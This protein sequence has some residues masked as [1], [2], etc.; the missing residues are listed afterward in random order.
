MSLFYDLPS[1]VTLVTKG[2]G[3]EVFN[4]TRSLFKRLEEIP[5]LNDS[6]LTIQHGKEAVSE[7]GIAA[8]ETMIWLCGFAPFERASKRKGNPYS[9]FGTRWSWEFLSEYLGWQ[10]RPLP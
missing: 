10:W 5:T 4:E 3:I 9:R 8:L 1:P 6:I 2:R 7:D